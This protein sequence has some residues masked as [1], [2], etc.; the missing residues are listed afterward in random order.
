MSVNPLGSS[1]PLS[2]NPYNN[3]NRTN[4]IDPWSVLSENEHRE[5]IGKRNQLGLDHLEENSVATR[6]R[7]KNTE[8]TAIT[9]ASEAA[10][11]RVDYHC[12]SIAG[13]D[14]PL[15]EAPDYSTWDREDAYCDIIKRYNLLNMLSKEKAKE[16]GLGDA[17]QNMKDEIDGVLYGGNPI[18]MGKSHDEI[19]AM[20]S[21]IQQRMNRKVYCEM[22][23]ITS[24]EEYEQRF[25]E[26]IMSMYDPA[27]FSAGGSGAFPDDGQIYEIL[28]RFDLTDQKT[29]IISTMSIMSAPF[30]T[31][32]SPFDMSLDWSGEMNVFEYIEH[33]QAEARKQYESGNYSLERYNAFMDWG[34]FVRD[35]YSLYK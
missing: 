34:A 15:S 14:Y 31:R 24:D 21:D 10:Q 3:R 2:N 19:V 27:N 35:M 8:S 16:L 32:F 11:G 12:Q 29:S 30:G 26:D 1:T 22:Y 9:K 5:V 13:K 7:V 18:K 20:D 6:A 17:Y 33:T 4:S 25:K 28:S 23:G